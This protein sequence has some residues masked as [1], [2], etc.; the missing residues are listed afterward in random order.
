MSTE[1]PRSLKQ[2]YASHPRKWREFC[3]VYPVISRRSKGLSIGVNLNP[4]KVCN[5][6]C[7]YCQV[8]RTPGS[9]S[10][11]TT[12][13]I[14]QLRGELDW[15]LG[16]AASGAIWDDPQFAGVPGELRRIND[17]AFSGDGEPTTYPRFDEAC[18][19]AA[20]LI[21]AHALPAVKVIVLTNMTMLHRPAVQRGLAILDQHPSEIWAKLDA[22][23][24]AYYEQVDRSAVKLDRILANILEAGR[25]RPIVIQ[26]LFMQLHGEPIPPEEFDAYLDRLSELVDQGCRIKLVQLYTI[27]RQTT[28]SYASPL[29]NEQLESLAARFR[30]RL[31]QVPVETYAGVEDAA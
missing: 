14:D 16:W 11:V 8:D 22:G 30:E 3:Y 19:L 13:D 18:Q 24:Q 31:P 12:V 29:T 5:W 25:A 2:L 17:I 9:I 20:D 21:A 4:D 23:T 10:A 28:E 7:V 1:S 26:S 27:A 15:M 6:D